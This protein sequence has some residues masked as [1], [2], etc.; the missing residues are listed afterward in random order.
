MLHF[1]SR[2]KKKLRAPGF[3][4][5]ESVPVELFTGAEP[6]PVN[7]STGTESVPVF[8]NNKNTLVLQ[9]FYRDR[10]CPGSRSTGTES[11]P[12]DMSTGTEFCLCKNHLKPLVLQPFLL[13]QN[14]SR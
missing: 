4:G 9:H 2:K 5:T 12:V 6:V 14:L 10:I 8:K 1:G 7:M 13:G 3:T 11:V